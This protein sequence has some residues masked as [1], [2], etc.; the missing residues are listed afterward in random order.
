M[1][2]G[3]I[4][5]VHKALALIKGI[6]PSL[7]LFVNVSKC[8][9][10]SQSDL[11]SFPSD[12]KQSRNLN[13]EILGIPIGDKDFCSAFVSR[14]RLEARPLLERL[15]E[16]GAVDPQVALMLLCMCGGFCQLAHLARA[17][18]PSLV[19]ASLEL[20]DEDVRRLPGSKPS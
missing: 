17:T 8:E 19:M 18:P 14:K 5:A 11:S 6:G 20:F 9:L 12:M 7:G 15:E 10:F 3:S 2:A 1:L 13:I 4:S 16:V